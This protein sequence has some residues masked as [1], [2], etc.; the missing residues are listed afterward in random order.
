TMASWHMIVLEGKRKWHPQNKYGEHITTL[1]PLTVCHC[2]CSWQRC[3]TW[4]CSPSDS[5]ARLGKA[6][7]GS[8]LCCGHRC[9]FPRC[10]ARSRSAGLGLLNRL[11][12]HRFEHQSPLHRHSV[13]AL[14]Q[15]KDHLCYR[16]DLV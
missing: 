7:L 12:F 3:S 8:P 11:C 9:P 6:R 14:Y 10:L 2:S 4:C 5:S 13:C 15:A 1:T 16:Y